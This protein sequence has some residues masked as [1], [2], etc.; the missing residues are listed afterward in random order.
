MISISASLYLPN[1]TR[2]MAR[3][4]MGGS[5]LVL[6]TEG[7]EPAIGARMTATASPIV[8]KPPSQTIIAAG[9]SNASEQAVQSAR[10]SER[11]SPSNPALARTIAHPNV[12]AAQY[13]PTM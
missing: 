4:Y 2:A 12:R 13:E 9:A 8:G 7:A 6:M 5:F 11:G 1:F 10:K 3:L